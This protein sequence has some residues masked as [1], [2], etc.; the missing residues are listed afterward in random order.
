MTNPI[1]FT[2]LVASLLAVVYV[3]WW[4][5]KFTSNTTDFYVA[6]GKISARLNGWAMFGDYCSAASF[7]GVAG[8]IALTG[9]DSWWVAIGFFGAWVFVLVILA[10]PLK[11]SG[12][13]L[14]LIH[15]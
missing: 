7:L 11:S 9:I 14:S 8:A 15:I 1:A 10:G 5:K 2:I 6:G 13:F 4:G 3:S 12:K